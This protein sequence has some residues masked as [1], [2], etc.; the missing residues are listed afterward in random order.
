[1]P[2]A[3]LAGSAKVAV[4]DPPLTVAEVTEDPSCVPPLETV[5][6]TVPAFTV[7]AVLVTVAERVTFWE[8]ALNPVEAFAAVVV[9]GDSGAAVSVIALEADSAPVV[10]VAFRLPIAAFEA[11]VMFAVALVKL[12]TVSEFTATPEPKLT[13]VRPW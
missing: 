1:V 5:K 13:V 6:V 8:L 9:V 7:P 2:A 10:T 4:A 12:P 11:T 3:V